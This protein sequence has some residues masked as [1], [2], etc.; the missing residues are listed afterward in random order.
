MARVRV[1][2]HYRWEVR[3]GTGLAPGQAKA[4][5]TVETGYRL[6]LMSIVLP[7]IGSGLEGDQIRVGIRYGASYF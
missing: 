4:Y 5:I 1:R 2:P 6:V 3:I 7:R